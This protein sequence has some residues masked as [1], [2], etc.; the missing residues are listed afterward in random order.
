MSRL[1]AALPKTHLHLHFTG[2]MR[3]ATLVE[4]AGLARTS[5]LASV[6][7][8]PLRGRLLTGIDDWLAAPA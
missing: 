2:S 5:V 4:L 3:H 8:E 7:P 6:A 1:L